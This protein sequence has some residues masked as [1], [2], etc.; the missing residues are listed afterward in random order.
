MCSRI[1]GTL[2]G[3]PYMRDRNTVLFLLVVDL[4]PSVP[5]V[6][7]IYTIKKQL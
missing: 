6:P 5:T 4:Q 1:I 3:E 2:H 7:H